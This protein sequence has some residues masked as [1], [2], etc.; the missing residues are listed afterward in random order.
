MDTKFLR[1]LGDFERLTQD[2]ST[3]LRERNFP[4]LADIHRTKAEILL[5]LC[6]L[7]RSRGIDF[8]APSLKGRIRNLIESE[9]ANIKLLDDYMTANIAARHNAQAAT[10]RLRS[11]GR[12]YTID[13]ADESQTAYAA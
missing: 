2:E 3:A 1:L 8:L 13:A 4:Y 11:L 6:E 10:R 5:D 7:S 9:K 12:V